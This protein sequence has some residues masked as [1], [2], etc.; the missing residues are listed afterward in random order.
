MSLTPSVPFAAISLVV[1]IAIASSCGRPHTVSAELLPCDGARG[2]HLPFRPLALG[3]GTRAH[4]P[5]VTGP[6]GR[7]VVIDSTQWR[8]VW[9]RFAPSLPLPPVAF[10]DTVVLL[11]ATRAYESSPRTVRIVDVQRC[12]SGI[13]TAIVQA[14]RRDTPSDAGDRTIA[15]VALDRSLIGAASV[16]FIDLPDLRTR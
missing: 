7:E 15:A 4:A 11:V 13:V 9:N 1:L 12:P 6:A 16:K 10:A 8:V 5:Y 3:I 14:E 2:T